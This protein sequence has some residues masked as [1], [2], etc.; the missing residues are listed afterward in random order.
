[1]VPVQ[2]VQG[3]EV[4]VPIVEADIQSERRVVPRGS[5]GAASGNRE[6]PR[7]AGIRRPRVYAGVRLAE[8][9]VTRQVL[10]G[11]R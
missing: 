1:M 3:H 9:R 11:T 2:G 8:A 4:S 6:G 5:D 7:I 10:C